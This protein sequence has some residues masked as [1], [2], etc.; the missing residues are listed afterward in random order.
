VLTILLL[1][2]LAGVL[3]AAGYSLGRYRL[4]HDY[5]RLTELRQT[6]RPPDVFTPLARQLHGEVEMDALPWLT[7]P[8]PWDLPSLAN[9]V[10]AHP[11]E[12]GLPVL[13]SLTSCDRFGRD[14]NVG[15]FTQVSEGLHH[16]GV[17]VAG[18]IGHPRVDR[19]P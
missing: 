2:L 3:V 19:V 13:L 14:L 6:L 12:R 16:Q 11:T 10:A 18:W 4:R 1:V 5:A 7:G 17:D 15:Q 9:S 8:G